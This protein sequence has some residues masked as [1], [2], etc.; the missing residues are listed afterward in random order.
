MVWLRIPGKGFYDHIA[1][2]GVFYGPTGDNTT[3]VAV[4]DYFKHDG[5]GIGRGALLVVMESGVEGAQVQLVDEVVQGVFKRAGY[6]LFLKGN[7]DE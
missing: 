5:G 7:G 2:A 4:K 1:F 3:G 6:E